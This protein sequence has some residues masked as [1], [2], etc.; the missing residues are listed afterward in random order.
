MKGYHTIGIR[1]VYYNQL[2]EDA[3]KTKRTISNYIEF[4]LM[5]EGYISDTINDKNLT[6]KECNQ[7]IPPDIQ[8]LGSDDLKDESEPETINQET[9]IIKTNDTTPNELANKWRNVQ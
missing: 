4:I 8:T 1:E 5:Q 9:P 3:K 6:C 7:T 2:K